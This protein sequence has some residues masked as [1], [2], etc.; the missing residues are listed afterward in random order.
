MQPFSAPHIPSHTKSSP[1]NPHNSPHTLPTDRTNVH[2]PRTPHTSTNVPTII[3][4]RVLLVLV[5]YLTH[6]LLLVRHKV[7]HR[8]FS[9]PFALFEAAFVFVA[10]GGVDDGAL[11]MHLVGEPAAGVGVAVLEGHGAL[12]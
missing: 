10:G 4:Q 6:L 3:K 9:E 5:A 11:A 1:P 8:A 2:L 7:A 12:A